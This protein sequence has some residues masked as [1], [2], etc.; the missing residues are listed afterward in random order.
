MTE[1]EFKALM[2]QAECLTNGEYLRGYQIGLR[3][4]YLGESL[5]T[6]PELD[7]W[8]TISGS[9]AELHQGYRDGFFGQ[10]PCRYE[11]D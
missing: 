10:P 11:L 9:R 2:I 8:L 5:G 3:R 6:D 4:H 7:Q 1:S